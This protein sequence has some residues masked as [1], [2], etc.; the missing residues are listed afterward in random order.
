MRNRHS[1][2]YTLFAMI[3]F[4]LLLSSTP[5]SSQRTIDLSTENPDV[6]IIGKSAPDNTTYGALADVNGD[7]KDD[8]I[9][10]APYSDPLGRNDAGVVYVIYGTSSLPS[11]I[12]LSIVTPD[13]TIMGANAGDVIGYAWNVAAG[14]VTGDEFADILIGCSNADPGGRTNAGEVYVIFGSPSLPSTI[15]LA[16]PGPDLTVQG[17]FAN[18]QLSRVA[19]GDIN[20]DTT[21]DLLLSAPACVD[22]NYGSVYVIYGNPSLP[23]LIDLSSDNADFTLI[24]PDSGNCTAWG[25]PSAGDVN[26]DG[27]DDLVVGAIYADPGGRS[28]AGEVYVIYGDYSLPLEWDLGT[29]PADFT[30]SGDDSSDVLGMAT[31][32]GDVNFDGNDDIVI[33]AP[34]ADP[35]GGNEAGEVY[36]IYGSPSLPHELDLS[37][38][39]PD[40]IIKGE[41]PD[42][43]LSSALAVGDLNIDGIG[44]IL[45]GAW[46]A[47]FF[48]GKAYVIDG[49]TSLPAVIDLSTTQ[50]YITVLAEGTNTIAGDELSYNTCVIGDPNGDGVPQFGLGAPTA[51]DYD[52][53]YSV[54]RAYVL[55]STLRLVADLPLGSIF[56]PGKFTFDQSQIYWQVSGIRPPGGA[57]YDIYLYSDPNFSDLLTYSNYGG[58]TVDFVV[59][60]HNH[61]PLG[62]YYPSVQL[63]SGTGSYSIEYE[64]GADQLILYDLNGPFDW[65][66]GHVV[67]AWDVYMVD[68]GEELVFNLEVTDGDI[69]PGIALF[70]SNGSAYYAGRESAQISADNNGPG[71]GESLSYTVPESDWYGFIVW[72]N[73]DNPG[74]FT[75]DIN[76]PID[77]EVGIEPL[78][79][80][81]FYPGEWVE[82][83]VWVSNNTPEPMPVTASTY[84]SSVARWRIILY[85]PY[86]LTIPPW[87][88]LGPVSLQNQVPNN[89]PPLSAFICAEANDVHECYPI[90]I[91]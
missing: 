22:P 50:A 65:P 72:N 42:D 9:L 7:G 36:V 16:S 79:G 76:V 78:N 91:H 37:A 39:P 35:P 31:A 53:N 63:Y 77:L 75:I 59:V 85:G 23:P 88:T 90:T 40:C 61:A 25:S 87:S 62:S 86:D 6:K 34:W 52:L 73:N 66:E 12:D 70:K 56:I 74:I 48:D 21:G 29:R 24:E 80:H 83:M 2:F 28:N 54:G 58:N 15:D 89:A 26:H 14:D 69:D 4:L 5:A 45:I 55:T 30:V 17:D 32:C 68:E 19:V 47:D 64:N 57:D 27:I 8:I 11:L 51:M 84:A 44:D 81:D 41:N 71:V 49:S 67:H 82:Y 13:V 18:G 1:K 3:P 38:T 20:G 33:G 60:D 46:R 43:M 10:D